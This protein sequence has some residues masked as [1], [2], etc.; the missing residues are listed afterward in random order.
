MTG[1]KIA[2]QRIDQIDKMLAEQSDKPKKSFI[3]LLQQTGMQDLPTEINESA[4]SLS[5]ALNRYF[6]E[7]KRLESIKPISTSSRSAP[8]RAP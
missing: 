2:K 4:D 8:G 3:D 7:L 6:S 1:V 5:V